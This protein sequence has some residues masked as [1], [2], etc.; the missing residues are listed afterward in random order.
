[1]NDHQ[2]LF[3]VHHHTTCSGAIGRLANSS[4]GGY[5]TLFAPNGE[6]PNPNTLKKPVVVFGGNMSCNDSDHWIG[7]EMRWLEQLIE[8][9]HP[10]FA[11]CLGSQMLARVLGAQVR[12]CPEGSLECG[13][14]PL[15]RDC[16]TLPSHVYQWH[17]E[18]YTGHEFS[19]DVTVYARSPWNGG[20]C[21]AFSTGNVMGVQF[22]PEVTQDRIQ[23]LTRHIG[24]HF[25]NKNVHAVRPIDCHL[26]DHKM[27]VASVRTWL[28]SVL[29]NQWNTSFLRD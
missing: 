10:V 5:Q 16:E 17:G 3:V 2:P 22:H 18:G 8:N 27:Y 29:L 4:F 19:S 9:D 6:F 26:E 20:V 1:M 7:K 12:M 23:F 28:N 24:E 11:I 15:K 14:L 25:A 21:Q 13:Y